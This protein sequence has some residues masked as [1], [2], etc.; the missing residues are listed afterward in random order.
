VADEPALAGAGEH[1]RV[2]VRVAV[3]A[4]HQRVE[5]VGD[6]QAE[7]AV[8][9]AIHSHDQNGSAVLDLEVALVLVG[10][11]SLPSVVISPEK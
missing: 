9:A 2:N 6:V 4:A 8:G 7:H 3:D 10:H 1:H 5:L 11:G